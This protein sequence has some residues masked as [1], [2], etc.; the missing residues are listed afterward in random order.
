MTQTVTGGTELVA[1]AE[2][3]AEEVLFPGALATDAAPVVPV[4]R[5]DALGG[6]RLYG[7]FGP[8]EAGGLGADAVIG[9]LVTEVLAGACLTTAFV[10]AQ[11]HGA[12]TTT[13][14]APEQLREEWQERREHGHV[15]SGGSHEVL[16]C[17]QE[18]AGSARL[19]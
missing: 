6:A 2:R 7:L 3:V 18:P 14:R 11:H 5:L 19:L 15:I 8:P 4:D 16:V 9:G 12:V 17:L 1:R 10:W 13:A